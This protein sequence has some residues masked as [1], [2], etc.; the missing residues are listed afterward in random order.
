MKKLIIPSKLN[1]GDTARLFPFQAA[2]QGMRI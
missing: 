2:V 1:E